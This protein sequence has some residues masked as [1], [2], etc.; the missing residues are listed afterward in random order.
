MRAMTPLE[1]TTP[2][3][4]PGAADDQHENADAAEIPTLRQRLAALDFTLTELDAGFEVGRWGYT[5]R[6]ADLAD[7]RW[8]VRQFCGAPASA[9]GEST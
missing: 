2:D 1:A 7:L 9:Q 4:V 3:A 6:A 5:R 8:V